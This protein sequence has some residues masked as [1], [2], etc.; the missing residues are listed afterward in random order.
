M[1]SCMTMTRPGSALIRRWIASAPLAIGQR[2]VGRGR[3]LAGRGQRQRRADDVEHAG[4]FA[5]RAVDRQPGEHAVVGAGDDDM[6][7]D[8]GAPGRDHAGQQKLQPFEG[9]GAV[10]AIGGEAVDALGKHVGDRGEIALHRRALLPV[11]VDHLDEGAEADRDQEGDDEGGDGAAKR[12]LR[13]EQAVIGRFC[14]RLRQSLDRIGLDA[15]VRRVCARHA[16]DPQRLLLKQRFGRTPLASESQRFES[17]FPGLSRV[18]NSL[19]RN[20]SCPTE[21]A[22]LRKVS[23]KQERVTL[24]HFSFHVLG[25]SSRESGH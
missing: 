19:M 17:S 13:G 23:P 8:G 18:N 7:A 21:N 3:R 15:R 11:L 25:V 20:K 9:G 6:A 24:A 14:D 2:D 10:A 1:L 22:R 5:D 16:L 4:G 12:G